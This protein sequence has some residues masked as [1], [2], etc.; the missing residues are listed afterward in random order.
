[1]LDRRLIMNFDWPT[2]LVAALMS[3]L[4]VLNIYSSTYPHTGTATPLYLKQVYWLVLG[5][6]ILLLILACDYRTLIRYGYP[7]FVFCVGLLVLVIVLGRTTSGSQRWLPLGF[8]SFQPSE[9]AKLGLTYAPFLLGLIT[10]AGFWNLIWVLLSGFIAY[11][12]YTDPEI[13][14]ELGQA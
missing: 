8:I 5:F 1:M 7:F 10:G 12:F 6:G 2:L 14:R 4:G 11:L 3:A 9:I 13:K